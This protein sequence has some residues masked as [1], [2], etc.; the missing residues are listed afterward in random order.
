[1]LR[2]H[3]RG[4]SWLITKSFHKFRRQI[5]RQHINK[6]QTGEHQAKQRHALSLA[7]TVMAYHNTEAT[8]LVIF[9]V[10]LKSIIIIYVGEM[11]FNHA[12]VQTET[13]FFYFFFLKR[14]KASTPCFKTSIK[15][16]G[17]SLI[18]DFFEHPCESNIYKTCPFLVENSNKYKT[19]GDCFSWYSYLIQ[20][21]S[22]SRDD[23]GLDF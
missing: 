22:T 6:V 1:M 18:Y 19:P 23:A 9:I 7:D 10:K 21:K 16:S 12:C 4:W 14:A 3:S 8:F 2:C 20:W 11:K 13:G 17:V 5:K 15:C